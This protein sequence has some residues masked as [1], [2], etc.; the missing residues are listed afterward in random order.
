MCAELVTLLTVNGGQM[1]NGE[2]L[3]ARWP[4]ERGVGLQMGDRSVVRPCHDGREMLAFSHPGSGQTIR[5]LRQRGYQSQLVFILLHQVKNC[6]SGR[7]VARS[8]Q[9]FIQCI[10]KNKNKSNQGESACPY[11]YILHVCMCVPGQFDP[12]QNPL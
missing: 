11:K 8:V 10:R 2:G 1:T 12:S 5:G 3:V 6:W 7:I 9:L 4:L